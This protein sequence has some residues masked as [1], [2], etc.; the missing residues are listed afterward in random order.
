VTP[1][2]GPRGMIVKV[3]K[4][5]LHAY[6]SKLLTLYFHAMKLKQADDREH[7]IMHQNSFFRH[8]KI[9]DIDYLCPCLSL[10]HHLSLSLKVPL[11]PSYVTQ[12][13]CSLT[14]PLFAKNTVQLNLISLKIH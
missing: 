9:Y 10:L 11:Y 3:N 7:N 1:G 6:L 14:V 5:M 12:L 8:I 4:A 2:A 13:D